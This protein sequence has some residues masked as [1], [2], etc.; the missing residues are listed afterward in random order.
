MVKLKEL[1]FEEIHSTVTAAL[2]DDSRKL[3]ERETNVELLEKL[4]R[5]AQ[6]NSLLATS[7]AELVYDM[8]QD[9][10]S[11]QALRGDIQSLVY[12]GSND[13]ADAKDE[14]AGRHEGLFILLDEDGAVDIVSELE[15]VGAG[16]FWKYTVFRKTPNQR[17]S[18][19][20]YPGGAYD[21]K[22]VPN[23]TTNRE[24]QPITYYNLNDYRTHSDQRDLAIAFLNNTKT[25]NEIID[26][27]VTEDT[28]EDEIMAVV[29]GAIR[30]QYAVC[31]FT[32]SD[33]QPV[34]HQVRRQEG[35]D[36]KW[37]NPSKES[38]EPV[39]Y[40]NDAEERSLVFSLVGHAE[41]DGGKK[42]RFF[43][44]FYAQRLGQHLIESPTLTELVKSKAFITESPQNQADF[45][46]I[47]MAGMKFRA[48]GNLRNIN[49][50]ADKTRLDITVNGISLIEQVFEEP[51]TEA[52]PKKKTTAVEAEAAVEEKAEG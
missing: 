24:G 4:V 34:R 22:V 48:T 37:V 38:F 27:F 8:I 14:L 3:L 33:V 12:I 45:L 29:S 23:H 10:F 21:I 11:R 2:D 36:W 25:V 41:L 35:N 7:D 1:S 30:W 47:K 49:V 5:D 18:D 9:N 40:I 42:L 26:E 39:L 28:Y 16:G 6:N 20:W 13:R 32:V 17:V 19:P 43:I 31:E 52:E 44:Y 15:N 46:K 51:K 50:S